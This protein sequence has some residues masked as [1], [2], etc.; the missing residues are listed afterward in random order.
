MMVCDCQQRAMADASS[1]PLNRQRVRGTTPRFRQR[2][3]R[4]PRGAIGPKPN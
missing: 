3:D 1:R 2:A 4:P